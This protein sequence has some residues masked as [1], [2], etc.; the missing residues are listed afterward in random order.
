M[1]AYEF[2]GGNEDSKS[3]KTR[4]IRALMCKESTDTA[5]KKK[6][7]S[8]DPTG[9]SYRSSTALWR[10]PRSLWGDCNILP[11]EKYMWFCIKAAQAIGGE[12]VQNNF[13]DTSFLADRTTSIRSYIKNQD[14]HLQR[15]RAIAC[16][17]VSN[18]ETD[19][20]TP[21]DLIQ[22]DVCVAFE[23]V[24]G[25]RVAARLM[26]NKRPR[27]QA[28]NRVAGCDFVCKAP[29][30]LFH[31]LL[32]AKGRDEKGC[33]ASGS[34]K[35]TSSTDTVSTVSD[36]GVEREFNSPRSIAECIAKQMFMDEEREE[37]PTNGRP[38]IHAVYPS[39]NGHLQILTLARLNEMQRRGLILCN[40]CNRFF[41][42]M[43]G[44]RW[45]QQIAHAHAYADAKTSSDETQ[46]QLV[47]YTG[48]KQIRGSLLRRGTHTKSGTDKLSPGLRAA[49]DGDL[50][51]M[52]TLVAAKVFDPRVCVDKHGSSALLWAAGGGHLSMCKYLVEECG[53]DPVKH[54]QSKDGRNAL[55]WAARNGRLDVCRWLVDKCG[56][57]PNRGTK[58][59]TTPFHWAVWQSQLKVCKWLVDEKKI[60]FRSLNSFGCNAM[61]WVRALFIFL[62]PIG[63][64]FVDMFP[65]FFNRLQCLA[66]LRCASTCWTSA[67]TLGFSTTMG[68]AHCTRYEPCALPTY[69]FVH[70]S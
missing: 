12:L 3:G 18:S 64:A 53:V 6:C 45:H 56:L 41:K 50:K 39:D 15:A 14:K 10:P 34:P 23:R 35:A 49:K 52:T 33:R 2:S 65:F 51:T 47:P 46:L 31:Q 21:A 20:R 16:P 8:E 48:G 27:V 44:I 26:Q 58:D 55:H 43:K 30:Y 67:W 66:I 9:Q 37:T 38:R 19:P 54:E 68:T 7:L 4:P 40:A 13:I 61:Q 63:L 22:Q 60:D 17:K 28:S 25:R 29:L 69:I 32:A 59:G 36:M 24:C 57:P 70:Y 11:V 1:T 42:G 5:Y 62:V